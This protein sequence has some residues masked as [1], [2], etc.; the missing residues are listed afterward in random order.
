[1]FFFITSVG[2]CIPTKRQSVA[3]H[4][5]VSLPLA[6]LRYLNSEFVFATF[7]SHVLISAYTFF[8]LYLPFLLI[9]CFCYK[10]VGIKFIYLFFVWQHRFSL[11]TFFCCI[12]FPFCAWC[13]LF[14]LS[15]FATTTSRLSSEVS[16]FCV[17]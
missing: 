5:K 8:F 1:M 4:Y 7:L 16:A 17:S 9:F 2:I 15:Q 11:R 14:Y 10:K 12:I 3:L 6:S 13:I